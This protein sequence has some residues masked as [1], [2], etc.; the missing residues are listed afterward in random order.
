M[1]PQQASVPPVVHLNP[2]PAPHAAVQV[3]PTNVAPPGAHPAEQPRVEKVEKPAHAPAEAQ[4][5]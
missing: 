4:A 1:V 2:A 5:K 3:A